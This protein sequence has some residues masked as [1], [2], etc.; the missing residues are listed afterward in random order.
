MK[1][2]FSTVL[3]TLQCLRWCGSLSLSLLDLS[4]GDTVDHPA[5]EPRVTFQGFNY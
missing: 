1:K 4:V 3:T 5:A 2:V